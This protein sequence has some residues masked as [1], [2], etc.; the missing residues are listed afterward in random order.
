MR[1]SAIDQPVFFL[2]LV[3]KLKRMQTN[4]LSPL[5]NKFKISLWD[6]TSAPKC[7]AFEDH[8]G[9]IVA[10]ARGSNRTGPLLLFLCTVLAGLLLPVFSSAAAANAGDDARED[11]EERGFSLRVSGFLRTDYWIDSRSVVAAREDIF[12]LYPA[13]RMPDANGKDIHGDPVF[14]FSAIASRV[15][16]H[17]EGPD[18]FGARLTGLVEADFTGVTDA[19]INGLRLRHGFINLQ[20]ERVGL[21]VG[22]WWHPLFGADVVPAVGSL[23]FGA[24]F[25]PFIRNPQ[26]TLTY[27][28]G[29]SRW[30]ASLV[31]QRDMASDGPLGRSP[32]YIRHGTVPNAH[33]QWTWQQGQTTLGLAGDYKT[34]R[35]RRQ[36]ND[37]FYTDETLGTYAL[38][39]YGRYR[40]QLA[41]IRAK[42]I[43]GQNLSEHMLLGGYAEGQ[44]DQATGTYSYTPLNH[45]S[46]WTNIRV[47]DRVA[48]NLF[49]GYSRNFGASGQ[50]EGSYYGLGT[51]IA[52]LWR[53]APSATITSGN[54][55]LCAEIIY[56]VAAYGEPGNQGRVK[57][58]SEVDNTRLLLTA[59]YY[60]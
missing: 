12:L 23:N 52:Y 58:H 37:G 49:L 44:Y 35:P 3:K 38:M 18:A 30:M 59:V 32:D 17:M 6:Q 24:P 50:V 1:S 54:L 56:T 27:Q 39:G 55:A 34:I 22:Q 25:Q 42:V 45:L 13:N 33:V 40:Y 57:N 26:A 21:M 28:Y 47:G 51:D 8:K 11:Q 7:P 36:T 60:F 53:V 16:L 10:P 31:A 29:R 15:T 14:G 2:P 43:Y 46:A 41:D 9:T 5:H 20:W 48:G 4:L 19:Q